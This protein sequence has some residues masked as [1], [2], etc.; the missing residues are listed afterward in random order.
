MRPW[1]VNGGALTGHPGKAGVRGMH[2]IRQSRRRG[3]GGGHMIGTHLTQHVS[4]LRLPLASQHMREQELTPGRTEE[5]FL[6]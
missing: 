5:L 2:L 3:R 4:V 1:F 6:L